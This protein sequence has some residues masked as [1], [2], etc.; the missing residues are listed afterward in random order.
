M[1]QI[2]PYPCIRIFAFTWLRATKNPAYGHVLKLGKERE[3]AIFIDLGCCCKLVAPYQFFVIV[4]QELFW[5]LNQLETKLGKYV[6]V[7][8]YYVWGRILMRSTY[9]VSARRIPHSECHCQ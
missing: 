3:N 8:Q 5:P 2:Y 1:T 6:A 4:E 9:T 7:V